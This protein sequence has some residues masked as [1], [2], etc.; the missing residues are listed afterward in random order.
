MY[1]LLLLGLYSNVC[2]TK[3]GTNCSWLY[4]KK[5]VHYTDL[6]FYKM[7]YTPMK[8]VCKTE[9]SF[10]IWMLFWEKTNNKKTTQ[11]PFPNLSQQWQFS[12]LKTS[13]AVTFTDNWDKYS[14][15]YLFFHFY[16]EK[17]SLSGVSEV[18]NIASIL[19]FSFWPAL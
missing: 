14:F 7:S 6:F 19:V 2:K 16:Q 11:K 18:Q 10:Q 1:W 9:V 3:S 13:P 15:L 5:S 4:K 8:Q 17:Y 12:K